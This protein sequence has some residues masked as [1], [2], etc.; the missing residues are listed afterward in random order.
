MCMVLNMLHVKVVCLSIFPLPKCYLVVFIFVNISNLQVAQYVKQLEEMEEKFN[1]KARE[2]GII[3][4]EL[5]MIKEFRKKKALL[6]SELEDVR[7]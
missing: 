7:L 1:K 2:I 5:K 4:I 3:Q 6:E